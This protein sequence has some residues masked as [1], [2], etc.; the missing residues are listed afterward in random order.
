MK[1]RRTR[2]LGLLLGAG[3]LLGLLL[4]LEAILTYRYVA[5]ELVVDHLT[6][7]AGRI[8]SRLEQ[9]ARADTAVGTHALE[10]LLEHERAAQEGQVVWTRVARQDGTVIAAA[11]RAPDGVVDGET[12]RQILDERALSVHR[13]L[14]PRWAPG[15]VVAL[16]FRYQLPDERT[17]F[18]SPGAEAPGRPR[19][20]VVEL[21]LDPH[22]PHD[23]FWP[24]VRNLA[25]S[26]A[27]ALALVA[28]MVALALLMPRYV[29][30]RRVEGQLAI[31]RQVQERLLPVET[32]AP[33][34]LD[35]AARCI[36]TWGVGGDYYDLFEAGG[37]I[38]MVVADVSGKGLPAAIIAGAVHGAIRA[39]ASTESAVELAELARRL[40]AIVEAR[41]D[42]NRFVSLFWGQLD[43]AT[44]RLEYVNAGHL[45]PML[46]RS[47]GDGVTVDLLSAG[48]PVLGLL[49]DVEYS[50]GQTSLSPGDL[51]VLYS[52]GVT[53]AE[54]P[55]GDDFGDERL[56]QCL[57]SAHGQ[58]SQE[59][60]TRL[61]DEVH[62][63]TRRSDF[64]DDLTVV[65]VSLRH[66]SEDD[67]NERVSRGQ[68]DLFTRPS[69][70]TKSDE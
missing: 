48:G 10:R 70:A 6:A 62:R 34:Q 63:F 44:S 17:P 3:L 24:L 11:G 29:R 30:A 57:L 14:P 68:P 56:R 31:A 69:A 61:L 65:A 46:V 53:E 66:P 41:T 55:A 50:A 47:S 5:G 23:P 19:F 28:A 15:L 40:N 58:P 43:P 51:L 38:G 39:T 20:K 54:T 7:E 42:A 4:L 16:P 36:P 60:V 25:V 21:A 52:D 27:A 9:R 2:G 32:P 37:R 35:I 1:R 22:G 64:A 45:P 26:A 49:P 8:V 33:R 13:R 12:R 59:V 67:G 18:R